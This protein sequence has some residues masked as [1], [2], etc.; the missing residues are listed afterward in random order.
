MDNTRERLLGFVR[1][2]SVAHRV[3]IVTALAVLV[4]LLVM[5][6]RWVMTPSYTVL[7]SG[8]ADEQVASVVDSLETAGVPYKLE[9]GG[10]TVMVP[11]DQLYATRADLAASGVSGSVTPEGWELLDSQGLSVSDFRQR[12]DYQRALEGE[13]VKTLSAMDG[14]QSAT[15]RLVL[16]EDELFTEQAKPATA[17]VL[18][19]TRRDLSVEEVETVSFLVASGVEGLDTDQITVADA[20]GTTLHAPGDG[21]MGQT[22]N[23]NLRQTREFEQALA[24]DVEELLSAVGGGPAS[25]VV[26]AALD[27]DERNRETETYDPASQVPLSEQTSVE[28]YAGTGAAPGGVVGVDGGPLAEGTTENEYTK[29]ETLSQ[30]GVDKV[31]ETTK[32][33]PGAVEQMSVAIVMDDGSQTGATVPSVA[34]VERLVTSA[35]GLQVDRGDTIA[36]TPVPFP[37]EAEDDTTVDAAG[38]SLTDM[39]TLIAALFVLIIVAVALFLMTR[40]KSPAPAE[41]EEVEWEPVAQLPTPEPAP[42]RRLPAPDATEG[43]QLNEDVRTLVGQQPDEIAALL[44]AWLA[45]RRA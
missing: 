31:T 45:D 26:R 29:E 12:V 14:I 9:S 22:T 7:Y 34:E 5:F 42:T 32:A 1:S 6:S 8:L 39:L 37:A 35:L 3:V 11:Q 24:S 4:M 10:S 44:R 2:L 16:P 21:S 15:V 13:L 19:N 23:R 30:Y 33:A 25:V 27:F 43:N 17:S 40:R 41:P 18:L 28:E 20:D 36:V 38:M